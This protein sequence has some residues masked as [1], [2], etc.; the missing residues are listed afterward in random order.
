MLDDEL[1]FKVVRTN[2]DDEVLARSVNLLLGRAA[3]ENRRQALSKGS[4]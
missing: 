4:D 1:P 2:S 3:Y